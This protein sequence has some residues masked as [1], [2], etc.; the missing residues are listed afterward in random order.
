MNKRAFVKNTAAMTV[1]SLILRTLG[2]V[3][4]IF[5]SNRVGAEGMGLYQLVFSVYVL[6]TTFASAG[7]TTAV[8]CLVTSALARK[9]RQ[10][11][12]RIM[13]LSLILSVGIGALTAVILY[14]GAP[15]IGVLMG[16]LRTIPALR[17]SGVALP[18]IGCSSCIK[19]YFAAR[20]RAGP[21]CVSQILE[22]VVRIGGILMLLGAA[23]DTCSL[24]EACLIILI[25]DALSETVAFLYLSICYRLD[26]RQCRLSLTLPKTRRPLLRPLLGIAMPLTAGRY[27]ATILRTVENVL[28][29]ARLTLF[30]GSAALSLAQYGAVKGMA[31]PLVFFPSA[32]L[33]TVSGLLIPELADAHALGQRRQVA[34]LT[35]LTVRMTVAGGI[36]IG[37]FFTVLG[38]A[39]GQYL[40]N[41]RTV[42][43]C[44]QILGPL[45]PIMYM[46]SVASGML[47]GLGEQVRSL[48][49]GVADSIVRIL[50]ILVLLPR[51]G[52]AGFL[53][54]MLLSNL[55]TAFLSTHRLLTV[56]DCRLRW[57]RWIGLPALIAV[58]VGSMG[59][60]A[61]THLPVGLPAMALIGSGML[62][63]YMVLILLFRCF[64]KEDL[65][66][67][68]KKRQ[69]V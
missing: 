23:G 66:L 4:R 43:L 9:D 15:L 18:F 12:R 68:K 52:I 55:L 14:L 69:P 26:W 57:G 24:A 19:G 60:M 33:M 37:C 32:F 39:L 20:R 42:G 13:R 31:L 45:T 25:G 38:D 54:V 63:V 40:Y 22:Q 65:Q 50:L 2:I 49:Y 53:F 47:K 36:L 28:V 34:R 5:I 44:L 56:S 6:G 35:A 41:D 1:T 7:L 3:F 21:P 29:P 16:D 67:L 17:I 59:R 58:G 62:L 27:L 8:T 10:S 61:A 30:T 48:W 11:I 51:Y 64:T 46:D